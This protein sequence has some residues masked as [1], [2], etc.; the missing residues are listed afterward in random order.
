MEGSS[1]YSFSCH[2]LVCLSLIYSTSGGISTVL[3]TVVCEHFGQWAEEQS[4]LQNRPAGSCTI[5]CFSLSRE[6]L[7]MGKLLS[8]PSLFCTF[9]IWPRVVIAC[10]GSSPTTMCWRTF[11]MGVSTGTSGSNTLEWHW[12]S[13]GYCN[14]AYIVPL[15]YKPEYLPSAAACVLLWIISEWFLKS[16]SFKSNLCS[17]L[18]LFQLEQQPVNGST[19]TSRSLSFPSHELI[20][21]FNCSAICPCQ[22]LVTRPECVF[23]VIREIPGGEWVL[24][25]SLVQRWIVARYAEGQRA[26]HRK[27]EAQPAH[28]LGGNLACQ[29]HCFLY[30]IHSVRGK[31]RGWKVPGSLEDAIPYADNPLFVVLL[32]CLSYSQLHSLCSIGKKHTCLWWFKHSGKCWV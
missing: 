24:S 8:L 1:D 12:L 28:T 21:S 7:G 14:S 10:C 25:C 11:C 18:L 5:F 17:G 2:I 6:V 13:W 31:K 9:C 15:S 23:C 19:S 26:V 20:W 22:G 29:G 27:V 32:R 4:Q 16:G 30:H 3:I